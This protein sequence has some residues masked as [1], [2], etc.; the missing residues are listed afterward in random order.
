[1][2]ERFYT[3]VATSNSLLPLKKYVKAYT[4]NYTSFPINRIRPSR[5]E[6]NSSQEVDRGVSFDKYLEQDSRKPQKII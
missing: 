3:H 1:M 6:R 4:T 2:D 5:S